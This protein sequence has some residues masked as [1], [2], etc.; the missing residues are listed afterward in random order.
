M[1]KEHKDSIKGL[2]GHFRMVAVDAMTGEFLE[3]LINEKNIIL[4][5]APGQIFRAMTIKDSNT[6]TVKTIRL[7]SDVGTGSVITPQQPT[8]DLTE[9]NQT[10][11]WEI[12]TADFN[13]TYNG[14]TCNFTATIIGQDVMTGYPS[15]PNV[16]YTSATLICENGTAIAY[17]RFGGRT[18]S[19]AI[20]IQTFWTLELNI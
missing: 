9:A 10:L 5:Q 13:V 15:Q 8:A 14:N 16:V 4:N 6:N 19:A 18:I 1:N 11:V 2:T 3:E 20:N 7:G 12:P 17:K